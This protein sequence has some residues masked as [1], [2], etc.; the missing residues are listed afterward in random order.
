MFFNWRYI[1]VRV[2]ALDIGCPAPKDSISEFH[3]VVEPPPLLPAPDVICLNFLGKDALKLEW[4]ATAPSKYF[5]EMRLYKVH[6]NGQTQLLNTYT[7]QLAGAYTDSDVVDP[8]QNNYTYY[9]VVLNI[10]DMVGPKSYDVS[11]VKEHEIPVNPTYLKTVTVEGQRLKIEW[12]RSTEDDFGHYELYKSKRGSSETIF[13]TTINHIDSLSYYDEDVNVNTTS[14]CY[15][16]RVSDDCGHLSVKSN[17]GCSIVIRGESLPFKFDL[18]WDDYI[19]WAGGV[20]E[21]E[22]MRANDIEVLTP[23]VRVDYDTRTYLDSDLDYDWGGY[24]YS[25]IAYEA[26]GS[27]NAQS[28][29]N[30]IYLVQP[31]LLHVPNAFTANNDNLNDVFSWSD[32]FVLDFE[33]KVYNRWG[34]KVFETT[35]KN[36]DWSGIYKDNELHHS[37]VYVWVVTYTGWDRSSHTQKG[38]VTIM[39]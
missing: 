35:D 39:R 22:L 12:L 6:P 27:E 18:N 2:R 17:I 33:M 34:E 11:S 25:V 8:R 15:Q 3:I 29:S 38:T 4:N 13:L 31:P 37:N 21:Y 14:Y 23:I 36:A 26:S 16:V 28:R 1:T 5:K 7:N 24:W 9:M 20:D 19:D 30:D 32:V 10:C